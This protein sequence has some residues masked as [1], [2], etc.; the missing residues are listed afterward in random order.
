MYMTCD[1]LTICS[2]HKIVGI[3]TLS[4]KEHATA[5]TRETECTKIVLPQVMNRSTCLYR[6]HM[7]VHVVT[8]VYPWVLCPTLLLFL[9]GLNIK[10]VAH[11]YQPT[12]S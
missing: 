6:V 9:V 3:S 10:E 5:Q 1:T 8:L 7:C 12:I 4:R 11:D 2:D